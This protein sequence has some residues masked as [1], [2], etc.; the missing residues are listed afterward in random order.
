MFEYDY[1]ITWFCWLK[2]SIKNLRRYREI[3]ETSV[4][5]ICCNKKVIYFRIVAA[6][7]LTRS[8]QTTKDVM[9]CLDFP[10]DWSI[11]QSVLPRTKNGWHVA[12][13]RTSH[14]TTVTSWHRN[15]KCFHWWHVW[16]DF[17]NSVQGC[18]NSSLNALE[19]LQSCTLT[20]ICSLQGFSIT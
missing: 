18:G 6:H 7:L 13:H 14:M 15:Q 10:A 11:A 8:S 17:Y 20:T 2:A 12:H 16:S 1:H 5:M 9:L 4:Y 3:N 19:L